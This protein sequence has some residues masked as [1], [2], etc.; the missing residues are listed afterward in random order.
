MVAKNERIA[1]PR[2]TKVVASDGRKA[3]RAQL[4]SVPLVA[5]E[6]NCGHL[7][8]NYGVAKKEVFFCEPCGRDRWVKRILAQ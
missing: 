5:Y 1:N 3:T 2:R 8:R 4:D 7:G 6:L